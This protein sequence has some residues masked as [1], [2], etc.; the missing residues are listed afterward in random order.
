[1]QTDPLANMLISAAVKC[2]H[3]L[4]NYLHTKTNQQYLHLI[5]AR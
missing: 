2:A 5:N 4:T 3:Y 1:M